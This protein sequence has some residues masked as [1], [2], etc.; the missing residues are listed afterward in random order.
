MLVLKI[1]TRDCHF[2]IMSL[3]FAVSVSKSAPTIQTSLPLKKSHSLQHADTYGKTGFESQDRSHV[4]EER[5]VRHLRGT[6]K[7]RLCAWR[8][9]VTHASP[10][11]GSHWQLCCS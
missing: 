9:F 6:A 7:V 2:V 10:Q 11:G 8:H 4:L 1:V 3:L 5:Y